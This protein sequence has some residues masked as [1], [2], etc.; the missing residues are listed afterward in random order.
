MLH[1][2]PLLSKK[3]FDF[4][5]SAKVRCSRQCSHNRLD[6]TLFQEPFYFSSESGTTVERPAHDSDPRLRLAKTDQHSDEK[7]GASQRTTL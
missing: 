4:A 2:S 5:P 7:R 1:I 6:V 3:A